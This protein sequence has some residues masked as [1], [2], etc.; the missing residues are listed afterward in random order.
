[1]IAILLAAILMCASALAQ[2]MGI[3][4]DGKAYSFTGGEDR[5]S[6]DGKTF[7]IGEDSVLVQEDGK[8]DRLLPIERIVEDE[9]NLSAAILQQLELDEEL[10]AQ[11]EM[12]VERRIAG[13]VMLRSNVNLI[14]NA[15]DN[16]LMNAILYSP[17][18]A[19]IRISLEDR[20]LIVENTG[21]S[22]PKDAIAQ[23]F[24]PFYRIEQSRSRRSGGI[25]WLEPQKRF[26][27]KNA[28]DESAGLPSAA[29][30]CAECGWRSARYEWLFFLKRYSCKRWRS[31]LR[32]RMVGC[33]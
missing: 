16:V 26:K 14:S 11:K 23:L 31:V 12:G 1:M 13:N 24:R 25:F 30:V 21:V 17:V 18:G 8:P 2:T 5:Y 27:Y 22:I 19:E 28:A 15:Q 3:A 9:I 4:L 10:I 29:Y 33:S 6:I 20:R 7:I 32:A